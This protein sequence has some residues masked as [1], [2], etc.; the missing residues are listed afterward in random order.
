MTAEGLRFFLRNI[1]FDCDALIVD[2]GS[3]DENLGRVVFR[4][5]RSFFVFKESYF[6]RDLAAYELEEIF[7]AKDGGV[8]RI[9]K[10]PILSRL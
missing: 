2:F 4:F 7:R 1:A 6:W 8:F 3:A 5:V 9:T 10:F